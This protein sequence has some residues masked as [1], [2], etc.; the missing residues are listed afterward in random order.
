V[1]TVHQSLYYLGMLEALG[2]EPSGTSVSIVPTEEQQRAA[3]RHLAEW[4]IAGRRP[5]VGMAPGAAYGPAKRWFPERFAAV[6]DRL[7]ERFACPVLLFGSAGDRASTEAVQSAAKTALVDIAGRTSLG[8]AI[9]L[10]ACCDLF[11]TNDSGLMHVAGALGVP[12]VAVF[13]STDPKTTYPLGERT[14]LVR[15]PVDC[16]PCLRQECP[17]D[18]RCMD[19]VTVDEVLEHST[20][21]LEEAGHRR[22]NA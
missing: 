18:F 15:R 2:F 8:D 5:L 6:A 19:L 14:V 4:G 10:I 9:A 22:G 17:T 13:G 16:S 11:I 20:R 7:A 21:L 1:K 3:G 12:T